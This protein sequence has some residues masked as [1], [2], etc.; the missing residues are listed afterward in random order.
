MTLLPKNPPKICVVGD[1]NL[2]HADWLTSF[3]NIPIEQSFIDSF[4]DL[5]L[6]QL[7]DSSTHKSGNKLDILLCNYNELVEN[8]SALDPH[9]LYNSD[10][11]PITFAIKKAFS[12]KRTP[13]RTVY[14]LKKKQIGMP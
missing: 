4:N 7:V 13:K 10:H 2:P 11:Y 1:L 3:G 9:S 14:N 8:S 6:N 12:R 5:S